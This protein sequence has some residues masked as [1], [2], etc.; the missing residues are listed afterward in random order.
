M[1]SSYLGKCPKDNDC[2]DNGC[3]YLAKPT[4]GVDASEAEEPSTYGSAYE[5]EEEV[6]E[7]T[8]AF[9]FLYPAGYVSCNNAC[10]YSAYHN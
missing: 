3:D 5:S 7:A 4:E 9:S 6:D 1:L 10:Y 8:A 2:A